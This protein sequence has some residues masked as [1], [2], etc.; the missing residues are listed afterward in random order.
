MVK[1]TP[2]KGKN[3]CTMKVVKCVTYQRWI[4]IL[5]SFTALKHD[6][7]SV[8]ALV[9]TPVV[10]L[11]E[12]FFNRIKIRVH[13]MCK[14]IQLSAEAFG[15][16]PIGKFLGLWDV[17]NLCKRVIIHLVRDAVFIISRPFI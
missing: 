8:L 5:Q 10:S 1:F 14:E 4:N 7:G 16:E 9:Y 2:Q 11:M 13:F 3:I 17:A 12:G 15:I 6:I